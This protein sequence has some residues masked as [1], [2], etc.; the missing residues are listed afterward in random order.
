MAILNLMSLQI[1]WDTIKNAGAFIFVLGLIVF[2]HEL[3]HYTVAKI[4]KMH[5]YQFQIGFGPKLLK[6]KGKETTYA[7][8]IIPLG[9]MVDLREDDKDTENLRSFGAKKPWQRLLVILA[10]AF[11][12]FV[13]AYVIIIGIFFHLGSPTGT[14]TLGEVP[15]GRPAYEAGLRTGDVISH[16]DGQAIG[17]WSDITDII[18][19]DEKTSFEV[20]YR[21]QGNSYTTDIAGDLDIDGNYRIGIV[22]SYEKNLKEAFI[23][24]SKRFKDDSTGMIGGFAKLVTGKVKL[25]T[26]SGPVGIYKIV[27]EVAE[28]DSMVDLMYLAAILSINIGIFNLLPIPALDG[29]RA[30]FILYEMIMRKPVNK[31]K[32]AFVHFVGM[33]FLLLTMVALVVKDLR[34]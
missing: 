15:Q 31:E 17:G 26:V 28:R 3:G 25:E 29:G 21:R 8:G 4:N 13:L 34:M 20:T 27:G 7:I 24:G 33:V 5:V 32:E 22:Q 18:V 16:I 6:L 12:N 10:G 2:I 23:N 14:S 19:Q 1:P 30:V 11:M 9:G